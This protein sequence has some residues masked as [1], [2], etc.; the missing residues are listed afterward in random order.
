MS[1][2]TEAAEAKAEVKHEKAEVKAA[3]ALAEAEAQ[4]EASFDSLTIGGD[5]PLIVGGFLDSMFQRLLASVKFDWKKIDPKELKAAINAIGD[6]AIA[7]AQHVGK[8][9]KPA[10]EVFGGVDDIAID[11][12][13]D[14][15]VAGI[16][17]LVAMAIHQVDVLMPS[18]PGP[19]MASPPMTQADVTDWMN[20]LTNEEV[21]MGLPVTAHNAKCVDKIMAKPDVVKL[22]KRLPKKKQMRALTDENFL[23]KILAFLAKYGPVLGQILSL[24]LLFI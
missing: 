18:G 24:F 16:K 21:A 9:I 11:K 7:M 12:A 10:V 14:L 23:D 3:V 15:E 17:A 5:Q 22:I 2:K 20:S 13:T 1:K 8:A 6:G 4:I 19:F